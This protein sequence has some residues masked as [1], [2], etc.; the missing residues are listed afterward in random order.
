MRVLHDAKQVVINSKDII[1]HLDNIG[2]EMGRAGNNINQLAKHA[3]SLKLQG[4][5]SPS[6]AAKFNELLE[7]YIGMQQALET[8]LRKIIRAMSH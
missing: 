5:V 6:V 2:A 4:A 3:N 8:A 1:R 7:A